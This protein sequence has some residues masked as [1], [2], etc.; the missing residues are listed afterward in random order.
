MTK[1][2]SHRRHGYA[3]SAK[4]TP[5]QSRKQMTKVIVMAAHEIYF[6]TYFTTV[7]NKLTFEDTLLQMF[8]TL[9]EPQTS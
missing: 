7:V 8:K 3:G 2:D 1:D 5:N 4:Q 6:F 9:S